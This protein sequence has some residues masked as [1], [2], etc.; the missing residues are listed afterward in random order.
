MPRIFIAIRFDAE[1]KQK[2]VE[3]QD[4]LR[5]RGV[6]GR[7]CPIQNLHLTL[8][9]IG[10]HYELTAIRSAVKEVVFKPFDLRLTA[11]GTFPTKTGV[12]WCGAEPHDALQVLAR[13]LR[14]RLKANDVTY[15]E[16]L[17][18]PHISLLQEPTEIVTDIDVPATAMRVE[19]I[20][21]M[22]SERIDGELIYAEIE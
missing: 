13:Q 11:L 8:A 4:A 22:K 15:K 14:E 21:I 10:E 3:V 6:Q 2:L 19:Q 20:F 16:G 1:M 18:F 12:I 5:K 7:Y 17:F 9:F